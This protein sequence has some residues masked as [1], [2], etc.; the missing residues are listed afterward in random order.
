MLLLVPEEPSRRIIA[1]RK[2]SF[3]D[4][5]LQKSI[6][7]TQ[8]NS[9]FCRTLCLEL[10]LLV[11]NHLDTKSRCRLA[12][13]CKEFRRIIYDMPEYWRSLD[14]SG[15]EPRLP[16]VGT[17]TDARI[18]DVTKY[19]LHVRPALTLV[20]LSYSSVSG[21]L[22]LCQLC[23][24]CPEIQQLNLSY[25]YS[26]DNFALT[27]LAMLKKLRVLK[28]TGCTQLSDFAMRCA[29]VTI[30][31]IYRNCADFFD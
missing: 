17:S 5:E 22:A 12:R 16:L 24:E 28:L 7:A 13:V 10:I 3:N 30:G 25:C 14:L 21:A 9:N 11:F 20:D 18:L 26:I 23:S 31:E 4:S 27:W 6:V 2:R 19:A 15:R 29:F 1:R 8:K